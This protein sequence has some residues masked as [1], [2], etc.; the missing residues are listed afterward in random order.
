MF[1]ETEFLFERIMYNICLLFEMV[2]GGIPQIAE[3]QLLTA[4][5]IAQSISLT[6]FPMVCKLIRFMFLY[7]QTH[8]LK[9]INKLTLIASNF[10]R[11]L[12]VLRER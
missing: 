7:T 9:L 6:T 1:K 11:N 3:F 12:D 5:I 2:S 4:L 10:S 8:I